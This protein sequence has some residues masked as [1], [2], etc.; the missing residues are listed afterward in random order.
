[1]ESKNFHL[2]HLSLFREYLDLEFSAL[3]YAKPPLPFEYDLER[4]IDDFILLNFFIGNDFL[5]HLPDMHI[6]EGALPLIFDVYK[7]VLPIA[8][9]YLNED[10][11]LNVHRLQLVLSEL[12][13]WERDH[14]ENYVADDSLKRGGPGSKKKATQKMSI[15]RPQRHIFETLRDWIVP[16]LDELS[17]DE[18]LVLPG[19]LPAKDRK[20][21]A[22]LAE[23]LHLVMS[24]EDKTTAGDPLV[25]L[26]FDEGIIEFAR[27]DEADGEWKL[28]IH[29]ILQ[30]YENADVESESPDDDGPDLEMTKAFEKWKRDYYRVQLSLAQVR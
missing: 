16:A 12:S 2:L 20:F 11:Y 15:S 22:Q 29:R 4:V 7:K 3:K 18:Q 17:S 1:M 5:P 25:T 8:G 26:K 28:A 19:L 24:T 10:G 6:N 30:K 14:F 9:G 13:Q 23:K 27:A 21:L